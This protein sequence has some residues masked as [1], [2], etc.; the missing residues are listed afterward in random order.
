M[1]DAIGVS[2]LGAGNVG[3][4]VIRALAAG[5]DRYAAAVGRRLELRHV[6]VRD[7]SRPRD[8]VEPHQ[9]TTDLDTVLGDDRTSIVVELMGG[10]EPARSYIAEALGSSRH[11]VT[12]NKE[13]IAKHGAA[14]RDLAA[15]GGVRLLY[16]ASV[17]GGIPIISPLFRDLLANDITAV[18][19]IINGTTNYML[20]AMAQD[21]AD[22]ADALADAQRLGYAEPD[23]TADVEGHD[24]AFKLAILCGLAFHVEVSPEEVVQRGITQLTARDIRY[25]STLGYAI[26]LIAEGRLADGELLASV[27]PTLIARDEPLSKVDGVLNAVQVE[28][29]LVG[30]VVLEGP[31]AGAAPTAS[32]VLADVLDIARDIVAERRPPP[33]QEYRSMRVREPGEHH[34]RRYVRMTVADR[35]GVLGEIGSALGA[36][37]VSIASVVQFEVDE[38]AR[39]AEMV[40]TTHAGPGEA[41]EAALDDIAAS[42]VVIEVGSVLAMAG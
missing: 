24:A 33:P 3:G 41:L 6:L 12:A 10:E 34:A 29:D 39:T 40:L 19:A 16:E 14:L 11:V 20:T 35:P 37:G 5:A 25:A 31:G 30:R 26:K 18:T 15:E 42:E 22:Y 21:G 32:A 9:L 17:G 23:P 8:G 28:G 7:A 27:Q 2:L 36:R 1:T 13:V 38:D 4:G